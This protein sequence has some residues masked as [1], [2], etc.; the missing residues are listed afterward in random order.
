M[1]TRVLICA[2]VAL[3]L[4]SA[5]TLTLR[6]GRTVGTRSI[7][8]LDRASL[9]EMMAGRAVATLSPKRTVPIGG[10]VLELRNVSSS[11]GVRDVSLAVRSSTRGGDF[12]VAPLVREPDDEHYED[13][14]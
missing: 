9:V 14:Q 11:T 2:V 13:G 12:E 8:E 7:R 5:D 10:I 6:D 4:A 3:S 1:G